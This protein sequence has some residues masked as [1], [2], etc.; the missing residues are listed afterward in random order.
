MPARDALRPVPSTPLRRTLSQ[1]RPAP[2]PAT[3]DEVLA[4][5]GD[6]TPQV[7]KCR[8][9]RHWWDSHTVYRDRG[10][11]TLE[12]V[13]KCARCAKVLRRHVISERTRERLTDYSYTYEDGFLVKDLGRITK[14]GRVQLELLSLADFPDGDDAPAKAKKAP[15]RKTAAKKA[16]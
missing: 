11:G 1:P 10:T 8:V 9:S 6:W 16:G 2:E 15:A 14:A 13:E 4:A 12:I 5:A 3:P 7:I